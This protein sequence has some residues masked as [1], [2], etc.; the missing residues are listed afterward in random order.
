MIFQ[1]I[2][3]Y[4]VAVE[5]FIGF[6]LIV[7]LLYRLRGA[8]ALLMSSFYTHKL[9]VYSFAFFAA[10]FSILM[11][12][13]SFSFFSFTAGIAGISQDYGLILAFFFL[14]IYF[15]VMA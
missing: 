11:I 15:F 13:Y 14:D 2:Y 12:V 7:Y 6:S 9:K 10:A 1:I 5:A 4:V 8:P 3:S